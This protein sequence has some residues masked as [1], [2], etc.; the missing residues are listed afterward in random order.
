M[1]GAALTWP[2]AWTRV[3]ALPD[4]AFWAPRHLAVLAAMRALDTAGLPID[5][6]LV[7]DRLRTSGEYETIGG[8]ATLNHLQVVGSD[9][10]VTAALCDYLLRLADVRLYQHTADELIVA[11]KAEDLAA[12][13]RIAAQLNESPAGVVRDGW[14]AADLAAVLDGGDLEPPPSLWPRTDGRH[15][16]YA[17]LIHAFNGEPESGKSWAALHVCAGQLAAGQAVVYIDYESTAGQIAQRLRN[18]GASPD[19]I[20]D[21][22]GYFRPES[23]A[24]GRL[25][26]LEAWMRRHQPTLAVIDGVTEAMSLE[27][28][29]LNSNA[30]IAIW[31]DLLARR[32]VR[33]GVAAVFVDHVTKDREGRGRWGI[34]GQ[35]KMAGIDVAYTFEMVNPFGRNRE[36]FAK[37]IVNKDR[38]GHIR[39]HVGRGVAAE[40]HLASKGDHVTC[41]LAAPAGT[42]PDGFRPTRYMEKVSRALEHSPALTTKALRAKTGGQHAPDDWQLAIE[43]L[44]NEGYITVTRSG[45]A[46]WHAHIKPYRNPS[47][48]PDEE[49]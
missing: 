1:L 21:R 9:T 46:R 25:G 42:N 6:H 40:L 7:S 45:G 11:A 2:A 36:G 31:L 35:H 28:L 4:T 26:P 43:T 23:P 30:D 3:A 15:L 17:G 32:L 18:L 16:L 41:R 24:A 38:P 20:A 13:H 37:V 47:D 8:A 49:Y 22:V 39:E 27:Q 34:G 19:A 29:D 14:Q 33:H 48:E 44:A 10:A 12:C 5:I